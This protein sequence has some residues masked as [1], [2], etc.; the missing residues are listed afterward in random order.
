MERRRDLVISCLLTKYPG[1]QRIFERFSPD[2]VCFVNKLSDLIDEFSSN[3]IEIREYESL[4]MNFNEDDNFE[5]D[6]TPSKRARARTNSENDQ[7]DHSDP[8]YVN[9][10]VQKRILLEERFSFE[11]LQ[12]ITARTSEQ[13]MSSVAR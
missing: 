3:L 2:I 10:P 9:E 12:E 13:S 6:L 1:F 7:S 4:I 5:S 11:K 8:L